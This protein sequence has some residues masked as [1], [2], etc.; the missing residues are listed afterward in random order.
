V[1]GG[2]SRQKQDKT[3]KES[4]KKSVTL[5][6]EMNIGSTEK[7][8]AHK[9]YRYYPNLRGNPRL[10]KVKPNFTEHAQSP[11]TLVFFH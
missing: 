2:L 4:K 10:K 1:R 7:Y 5:S 3:V 9:Q 8:G 6:L 11:E